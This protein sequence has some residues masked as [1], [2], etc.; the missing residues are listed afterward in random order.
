MSIRPGKSFAKSLFVLS[1]VPF[2]NAILI[3]KYNNQCIWKMVL[4]ILVFVFSI[5]LKPILKI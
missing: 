1:D 2:K 3:H 4:K 5:F